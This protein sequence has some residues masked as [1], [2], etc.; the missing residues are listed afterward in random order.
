MT[1]V[2]ETARGHGTVD[3]RVVGIGGEKGSTRGSE[4]LSIRVE[5]ELQVGQAAEGGI[6]G[7]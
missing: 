1:L 6:W 4:E 3:A 7:K 2:R 5:A